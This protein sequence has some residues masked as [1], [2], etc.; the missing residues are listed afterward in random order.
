MRGSWGHWTHFEGGTR[1]EGNETDTEE[2]GGWDWAGEWGIQW[3]QAAVLLLVETGRPQ[4]HFLEGLW[5]WG[6]LR[7]NSPSSSR[8][9]RC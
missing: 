1:G 2:L 4:V 7:R 3:L 6:G 8:T 5:E 9:Q